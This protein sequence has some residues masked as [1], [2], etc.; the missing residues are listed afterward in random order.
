MTLLDLRIAGRQVALLL[1]YALWIPGF[2][3][4]WALKN[5][6]IGMDEGRS[7]AAAI[8]F[9]GYEVF[10]APAARRPEVIALPTRIAAAAFDPEAS[11]TTLPCVA[12]FSIYKHCPCG[13][14]AV[15][16]EDL[17][18]HL[19]QVHPYMSHDDRTDI[20]NSGEAKA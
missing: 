4:G 9:P 6:V 17:V 18:H 8:A 12:G 13:F 16:P 3:L 5:L 7:L 10:D 14:P 11:S 19:D 2:I 20:L 1:S 15:S